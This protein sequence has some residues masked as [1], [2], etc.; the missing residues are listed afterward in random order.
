[1]DSQAPGRHTWIGCPPRAACF[2]RTFRLARALG[3]QDVWKNR[4]MGNIHLKQLHSRVQSPVRG[5]NGK[6]DTPTFEDRKKQFKKK[7]WAK[8]GG[9]KKER[10]RGGNKSFSLKLDSA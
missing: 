7:E 10:Q 1:M 3:Y 9:E 2:T 5:L 8:K 6:P 4:R